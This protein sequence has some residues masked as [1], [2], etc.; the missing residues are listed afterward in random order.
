MVVSGLL[1]FALIFVLVVAIA[2]VAIYYFNRKN[3]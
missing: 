3:D 1:F 2:A